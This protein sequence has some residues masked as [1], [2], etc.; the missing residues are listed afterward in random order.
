MLSLPYPTEFI[1]D[2]G[3][4]EKNED[5]HQVTKQECEEAFFVQPS[6]L[7]SDPKHSNEEIRNLFLGKTLSGRKL[8]IILTVRENKVRVIS[9]RDMSK[10]E[11]ILYAEKTKE[12]TKF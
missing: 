4:N 12:N 1:W 7:M 8:S 9:A 10:K 5:R 2:K 6:I 11:R 3:N